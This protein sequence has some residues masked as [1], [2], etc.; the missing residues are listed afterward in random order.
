MGRTIRTML[1]MITAAGCMAIVPGIAAANTTVPS[2]TTIPGGGTIV[3]AS[4]TLAMQTDGNLVLYNGSQATWQSHTYSNPGARAVMQ[5]DGN[6]V[7]YSTA[8]QPLFQTG[9]YNNSGA[10]LVVQ[11][12]GNMV[13]YTADG[14]ALWAT[15]T[16][17]AQD[18]PSA[19][20]PGLSATLMSYQPTGSSHTFTDPGSGTQSTTTLPV[21]IQVRIR[22]AFPLATCPI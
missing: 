7:V 21:R 2:D 4:H 13:I 11:D 16:A 17:S 19:Q 5:T 10:Y 18:S 8:N 6:L 15:N 12:D 14:R 9:T 20:D 22:G 1:A 3:S